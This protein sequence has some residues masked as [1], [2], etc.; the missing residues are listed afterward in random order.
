MGC[1]RPHHRA[2]YR[3]APSRMP[4]ALAH[5]HPS[6]CERS[7]RTRTWQEGY[8]ASASGGKCIQRQFI[9]KRCPCSLRRTQPKVVMRDCLSHPG[10]VSVHRIGEGQVV[11][12]DMAVEGVTIAVEAGGKPMNGRSADTP[13]LLKNACSGPSAGRVFCSNSA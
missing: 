9:R 3:S 10:S 2:R 4:H 11:L 5:A 1:T 7:G 8:R 12:G 13:Y 6:K